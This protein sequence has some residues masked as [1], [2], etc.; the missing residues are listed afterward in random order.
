LG[1]VVTHAIVEQMRGA[2]RVDSHVGRGTRMV[3]RLPC[4][5]T[6]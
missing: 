3:V 6:E 1:L 5:K 2:I 4:I